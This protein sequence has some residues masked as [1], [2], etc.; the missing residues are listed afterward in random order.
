MPAGSISQM[1]R[2]LSS[3]ATKSA[4]EVAPVAPSAA[5]ALTASALTS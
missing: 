3:F 2:G 5:S 1:L 4:S